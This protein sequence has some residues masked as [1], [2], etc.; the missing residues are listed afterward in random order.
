M[1]IHFLSLIVVATLGYV[2]FTLCSK[3]WKEVSK[4]E[5]GVLIVGLGVSVLIVGARL[6]SLSF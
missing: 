1:E 4:I 6:V 3:K 2:A 5:A